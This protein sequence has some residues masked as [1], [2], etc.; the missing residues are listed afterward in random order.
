MPSDPGG[1]QAYRIFWRADWPPRLNVLMRGHCAVIA[2]RRCDRPSA[3]RC[4]GL[5]GSTSLAQLLAATHQRAGVQNRSRSSP[6]RPMRRRQPEAVDRAAIGLFCL[7][8]S[9]IC[10]WPGHGKVLIGG[11]IGRGQ[12][13]PACAAVGAFAAAVRRCGSG[14]YGGALVYNRR[15]AC[16]IQGAN[17]SVTEAI[18]GGRQLWRALPVL[19]STGCSGGL[20]HF[21]ATM[22]V[23]Q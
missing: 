23:A 20:R 8:R 13:R 1:T 16:A 11:V 17:Y 18:Y 21:R 22:L 9:C 10:S 2:L 14:R 6:L 4:G 19:G 15:Q 7:W 3:A 5:A 12:R